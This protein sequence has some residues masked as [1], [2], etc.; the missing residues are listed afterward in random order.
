MFPCLMQSRQTNRLDG[1]GTKT[2]RQRIADKNSNSTNKKRA[3]GL[4]V[5]QLAMRTILR[6][7]PSNSEEVQRRLSHLSNSWVFIPFLKG[8]DIT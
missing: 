6:G 7:G 5:D 3:Q 2:N 1:H 4:I 8:C